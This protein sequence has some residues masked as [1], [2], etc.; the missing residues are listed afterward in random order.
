MESNKELFAQHLRSAS[1]KRRSLYNRR[2]VATTFEQELERLSAQAPPRPSWSRKLSGTK[3]GPLFLLKF[4]NGISVAVLVNSVGV[5]CWAVRLPE[6]PGGAA[7]SLVLDCSALDQK[8]ERLG[9]VVLGVGGHWREDPAP[10]S[11]LLF[12]VGLISFSVVLLS[13]SWFFY[14]FRG[15]VYLCV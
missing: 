13:V 3:Q 14:V 6:L 5:D 10:A 11:C 1:G 4:P 2:L 8:C 7:G 12:R 9:N 15:P